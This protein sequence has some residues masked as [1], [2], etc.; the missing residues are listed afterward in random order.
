MRRSI[1]FGLVISMLAAVM[2]AAPALAAGTGGGGGGGAPSATGPSYDPAVEYQKGVTAFTAGQ[3][4]DA[5]NAFRK[6]VSVVPRNAQAQYLLGASLLG[7]GEYKKA[8]RPLD[9]AVKYDGSM[10]EA[11][12]DLAVA[13]ARAGDAKRAEEQLAAVRGLQTSC[14]NTCPDAAKLT[15]AVAAIEAAITAGVQTSALVRPDVQIADAA[16]VDGFYVAAVGL[17]NEH[18]YDEAIGLLNQALWVAGPH[19]D[20]LTYLGFANRK[21]KKLDRAE[22]YY[23]AALA[24]APNHRG[25][26]EYYG[27]LKIERGNI[28]GAR[29]NLA[30][31]DQLCGFG[32]YEADELRRWI[33]G[34]QP[35]AS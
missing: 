10:I 15:K 35:S 19:P 16:T 29:A 31:L 14:A 25:A 5:V 9:L 11:R 8:V 23:R 27:E 20:V 21:L 28:A 4:K 12:R 24:V 2:V 33:A 1:G 30:R 13:A 32:C 34:A 7:A 3:Y 17:I 22:D 26:L 18:R 6:V